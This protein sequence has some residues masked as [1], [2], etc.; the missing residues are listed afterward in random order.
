MHIQM[1]ILEINKFFSSIQEIQN[2]SLR[3]QQ[4]KRIADWK[5]KS[6]SLYV[7][8]Q[9]KVFLSSQVKPKLRV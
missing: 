2:I 7:Q 4:E 1:Q 8:K 5:I 9:L 6:T 3:T